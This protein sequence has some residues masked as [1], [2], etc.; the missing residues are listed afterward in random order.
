[1][2]GNDSTS[3][4][5]SGDNQGEKIDKKANITRIFCVLVALLLIGG[6]AA[7]GWLYYGSAKKVRDQKALISTL[8]ERLRDAGVSLPEDLDL[9]EDDEPAASCAGGSSYAADIGNFEITV[10]SPNVIIRDLDAG[11][12]GGPITDLA[13]GRCVA[14]ET[15]VVDDYLLDQVNILAHPAADAAELRAN[16]EAQWGS[17]LTAGATVTIDGV[18]AQTYT[19]EGLFMTKLVYFDHSGIGYQIEL[20]GT[21]ATAEATL[22]D[23]ITDWSF[24]P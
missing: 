20:P 3:E 6:L 14:G 21:S 12:E 16:F 8:E 1:M 10:S 22:T 11:F 23:V 19:G 9:G 15:N 18:T 4:A 2:V 24:T 5:K 17:P 13:I 7:V